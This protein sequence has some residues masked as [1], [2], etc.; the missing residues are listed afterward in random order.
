MSLPRADH[1][2]D[3]LLEIVSRAGEDPDAVLGAEAFAAVAELAEHADHDVDA[4]YL[5]GA[6]HWVRGPLVGDDERAREVQAA[7]IWWE[8]CFLAYVDELPGV[9]VPALA[10][11]APRIGDTPEEWSLE[12]TVLLDS[13]AAAECREVLD[14]AVDLMEAAV[15]EAPAGFP[16]RA[17]LLSNLGLARHARYER[18]GDP[19]DL[20]EALRVHREAVARTPG[21]AL[22]HA[23]LASAV[24]SRFGRTGARA[25]L[26][27]AI[28]L[29]R[30]AVSLADPDDPDRSGFLSNVGGALRQ[31]F[32]AFG[33]D[34]DLDEALRI[35]RWAL[36]AVPDDHPDRG[37]RVE[38]LANAVH[39]R[40][41]RYGDD[42]D[43]DEFVALARTGAPD[44]LAAALVERFERTG[45]IADLDEAVDL[46]RDDLASLPDDH[47]DLLDARHNLAVV[48]TIRSGHTGSGVDLDAAIDLL[49]QVLAMPP[50]R[51]QARAWSQLCV[52]LRARFERTGDPADL[53]EAIAAGRRAPRGTASR[54]NLG[55]ALWTRFEHGGDPDDL[56]EALRHLRAARDALPADHPD[57]RQVLT[58]LAI[59]GRAWHEATGDEPA[60]HEAIE[61]AT[62][63]LDGLPAGHPDRG[64]YLG[65]LGLALRALA[66]GRP[67]PARDRALDVLREAT[68]APGIAPSLGTQMGHSWARLA[69]EAGRPD[70]AARAW[71]TVFARLPEVTD[72]G[73][74][75]ADRQ[76]HLSL[77]GN[78]GAEAA[79]T[80][81]TLGDAEQAWAW[82]EQGRGVLLG[83]SLEGRAGLGELRR[84]RPDLA[85][86]VVEARAALDADPT[87][88]AAGVRSRRQ[89]T[90]RAAQAAGWQ[91][92]LD[93]IRRV[94]GLDRFGLP[95][96][97]AEL[98]R[99]ARGGTV[100][101][102]LASDEGCHALTMTGRGPGTVPLPHL[103]YDDAIEGA[104]LLRKAIAAGESDTVRDVLGWLWDTVTGPILE[105]LGH[106]APPGPDGRWPRVWWIP[107]GPFAALPLH[108]AGRETGVLDLVISSYA[109]TARILDHAARPG[110]DRHDSRILAIGVGAAAGMEALP[111]ARGEAEEAA[112][113][114]GG[115]AVLLRDEQATRDAV[116]EWLPRA[117]W[118]HLAC[119]ATT[120]TD[121]AAG[122]LALHDGP[123]TARELTGLD[124]SRGHLA[125]LSAC[126][127]ADAGARVP[128]E[129][130][131]IASALQLAGFTHVIGTLWPVQDRVSWRLSQAVY[132][133]LARGADPATAVHLAVR[134]L[135]ERRRQYPDRWA[136]HLHFGP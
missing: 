121:P 83:Q 28:D 38:C 29:S 76:H 87:P 52:A 81:L 16:D 120:A 123:L 12:A 58:N 109:P 132:G 63:A 79:V 18:T 130:I 14:R 101:A 7:L 71:A 44:L 49:R 129:S 43:L 20:D 77:V 31:R 128:D 69:A 48:L 10:R 65:N 4:A 1:L 53:D 115:D 94:P 19:G 89:I 25:D 98:R 73:L 131:H 75:R 41:E 33:D 93:E 90:D 119:H 3:V 96:S 51:T 64:G 39:A 99:A 56:E 35:L 47:P 5:L 46:H 124:L 13:S 23:N 22:F 97:P 111:W 78:L 68:L 133:H 74:G 126:M 125:Y 21:N 91:R 62:T 55:S 2:K 108:A 34:T 105:H 9:L 104:N 122:Y 102:V 88:D 92:L 103:T 106:T 26:D 15:A 80:A 95:P 84:V 37:R 45:D 86:R 59:V 113:L 118:V 110:R 114:L 60:L 32:E 57:R 50:A 8:K 136:A 30:R 40:F 11:V 36:D 112:A 42:A 24:L 134:A 85:D 135:R 17:G 6:W 116:R 117:R 27:E 82:L 72:H 127:T 100:V 107:T 67:G 54:A 61:A 66:G 70:E